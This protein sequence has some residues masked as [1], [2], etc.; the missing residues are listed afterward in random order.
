M[1][2]TTRIYIRITEALKDKA[3]RVAKER[4]VTVSELITDYIKRL[5]IPKD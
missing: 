3:E 5:P 2:K 4:E 1:T